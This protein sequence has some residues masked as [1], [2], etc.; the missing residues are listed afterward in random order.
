MVGS[1][2]AERPFAPDQDRYTV[3]L[4]EGWN[5][6]L[7]K[8]GHEEGEWTFAARLTQRAMETLPPDDHTGLRSSLDQFR[9]PRTAASAAA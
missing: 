7:V 5:P 2:E 6:L 8:L 4:R 1:R 3:E 9:L